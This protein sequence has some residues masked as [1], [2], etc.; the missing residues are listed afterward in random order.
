MNLAA[1]FGGGFSAKEDVRHVDL[2]EVQLRRE[3]L[4]SIGGCPDEI[5]M[6]GK[7][8]RFST[9][10]KRRD[11][12]GWYVA[13]DGD[14]PAGCFG[15]WRTG[16][17]YKWVADIGR[18]LSSAE[19]AAHQARIAEAREIRK[20]EEEAAQARAAEMAKRI[21][22]SAT[23]A[24]PDHPYLVSHGIN[25]PSGLLMSEYGKLVV[26][27]HDLDTG[28]IVGVQL[29]DEDGSKVFNEGAKAGGSAWLAGAIDPSKGIYI[30]EGAAKAI[31]IHE[32]TG[33]ACVCSFSASN[34]PDT[35]IAMRGRYGDVM[36]ITIIADR[37]EKG[38]G[39]R[40]GAIAAEK[41]G[42]RLIVMPIVGQDIND[43]ILSGGDA[44]ALL[45]QK[46]EA[47]LID[48][49]D[50]SSQPMPVKWLIKRQVQ[51]NAFMML[52]G[53][54][55]GGKT[56]VV[57]DMVMHIATGRQ[58]NNTKTKQGAVVYLAGEGHQGLRG[59]IA[60]W[61]KHHGVDKIGKMWLSSSGT[62]LNTPA[63]MQRVVESV[64][65]LPEIPAIIV[66]DTLHRF[67]DG[68]E[69]SAQDAKSMIDA[70]GSLQ[71]RFGCSVLLVHHTGVS[72]EAQHRARGS[73]AWRGALDIELSVLPDTENGCLQLVQM[74]NK[75]A[76]LAD[77]VSIKLNTV[78]LDW[79]D[80]DG[81]QVTSAVALP[82]SESDF[83]DKAAQ[84]KSKPLP[85]NSERLMSVIKGA[86]L[87]DGGGE[88]MD[89]YPAISKRS[90]IDW[91]GTQVESGTIKWARPTTEKSGKELAK[92]EKRNLGLTS[93]R[94]WDRYGDACVKAG[95]LA[96]KFDQKTGEEMLVLT[97][98][99]SPLFGLK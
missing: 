36:P 39:E 80:E 78:D 21:I 61:K 4:A 77:K 55:G 48:A 11:D 83:E 14:V 73:S 95:I 29:I 70:C 25:N 97:D 68:D 90:V 94:Q 22:A 76:E 62:D 41:S 67:L 99:I 74:K 91:L 33:I 84:D 43:F 30:A 79:I 3:I 53:P 52:H 31:A 42:A 37:D 75:D 71:R 35:A 24:P 27:M 20:K 58:W 64:E 93:K 13:F 65:S 34:L 60:A 2:P 45:L 51:E 88:L 82:L 85:E 23:T 6:D 86:W 38:A 49:D 1:I 12:A 47:W 81:E 5:I 96:V 56:F 66:V 16:A 87:K 8:R 54:S 46:K 92:D 32:T 89:G 26:P 18:E 19:S 69:N 50:F 17:H 63:G 10:N 59:R 72:D 7:M 44:A 57:L 28:D 98:L 15:D 9:S 40:F